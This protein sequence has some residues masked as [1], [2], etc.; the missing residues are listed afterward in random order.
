M[1]IFVPLTVLMTAFSLVGQKLLFF[2]LP[3][4][5]LYTILR[6]ENRDF[7]FEQMI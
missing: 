2:F 7:L 6:E 5:C 3:E 1:A 4:C